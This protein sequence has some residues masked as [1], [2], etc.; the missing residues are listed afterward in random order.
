MSA[1]RAGASCWQ[2]AGEGSNDRAQREARR[3]PRRAGKLHVRQKLCPASSSLEVTLPV[4]L[5]CPLTQIKQV[6]DEA[7]KKT[8]LLLLELQVHCFTAQRWC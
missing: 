8:G 5:L 2:L 4:L 6:Q 3:S 7:G 1:A